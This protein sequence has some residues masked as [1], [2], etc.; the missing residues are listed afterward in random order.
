MRDFLDDVEAWG[1]AP[2]GLHMEQFHDR[3]M[4][5]RDVEPPA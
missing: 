4:R 5:M 2:V 1:A 3:V